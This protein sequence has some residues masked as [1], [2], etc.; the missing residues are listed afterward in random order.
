VNPEDGDAPATEEAP[1]NSGEVFYHRRGTRGLRGRRNHLPTWSRR[2]GT[3]IRNCSPQILARGLTFSFAV[4]WNIE[5]PRRD[6]GV[7]RHPRH[8]QA[9]FEF[10]EASKFSTAAELTRQWN[11]DPKQVAHGPGLSAWT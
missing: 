7:R 9:F 3:A 8:P 11:E 2:T 6:A 5:A 1:R 10:C 4:D